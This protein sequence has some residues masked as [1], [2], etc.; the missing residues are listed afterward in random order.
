[1]FVQVYFHKT[2]RFLDKML[3]DFLAANLPNGKYPDNVYDYLEWHDARV[4]DMI[5]VSEKTSEA[6]K[7]ILNRKI[8]K[9]VYESP[10]HADKLEIRLYN[11]LKSDLKRTF[12]AENLLF[13]SADKMTHKIPLKYEIDSEQAIPIILDHSKSPSTISMESGIIKKM[14]DP[15][16]I[17]RIYAK[18]SIQKDA[19]D[20]VK[21]RMRDMNDSI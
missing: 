19:Q 3:V 7:R 12:G 8:M 4:W 21:Q 16:N 1:M 9:R 6:A 11:L 14:T 2:R 20:F 15:I 17:L 10:T 18:E 5:R 13:D